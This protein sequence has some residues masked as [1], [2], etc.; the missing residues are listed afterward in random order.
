MARFWPDYNQ[1]GPDRAIWSLS[2]VSYRREQEIESGQIV[3][4]KARCWQPLQL[5]MWMNEHSD[6]WYKHVHGDKETFHMAWR[7]LG[8][9]YAMPGRGILSLPGV[10]CQ[11]DFEGRRI[12]SIA[13]VVSGPSP[14]TIVTFVAFFFRTNA[15]NFF[16]N[17]NRNG[18]GVPAPGISRRWQCPQF[19]TRPIHS[20][21][22][23]G[24]IGGWD[25]MNG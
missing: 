18:W 8:Q 10:M 17:L 4:H 9:E 23:G 22:A 21:A 24:Y 1:L 15:S 7:K 5:A 19:A 14:R 12:F 20:A 25:M 16:E 3:L 6:F 2:G 11:H 13:T